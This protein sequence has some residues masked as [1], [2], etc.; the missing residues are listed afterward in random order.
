MPRG[1]RTRFNAQLASVVL[2]CWEVV[3]FSESL[4]KWSDHG[5][6]PQPIGL[7]VMEGLR[8]V[9]RAMGVLIRALAAAWVFGWL[10]SLL[11]LWSSLRE[12]SRF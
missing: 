6:K 12:A 1:N 9:R 10:I 2:R 11:T 5:V 7:R 3:L 8:W 4:L